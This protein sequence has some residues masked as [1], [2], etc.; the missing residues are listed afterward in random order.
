MGK[1]LTRDFF[2]NNNNNNITSQQV[3]IC[4]TYSILSFLFFN[5]G[6]FFNVLSFKSERIT[7]FFPNDTFF[8]VH[9]YRSLNKC[10]SFDDVPQGTKRA[11]IKVFVL[12]FLLFTYRKV[13]FSCFMILIFF[14]LPT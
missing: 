4:T 2:L 6:R 11:D 7:L 1:C 13:I 14:E 9:K 3:K 10:I 12:S 8:G 5:V